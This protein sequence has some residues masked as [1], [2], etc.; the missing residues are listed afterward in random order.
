MGVEK[1]CAKNAEVKVCAHMAGGEITARIVVGSQFVPMVSAGQS[2][3]IVVEVP[4][5]VMVDSLKRAVFAVK[6]VLM[7]K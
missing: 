4:Y 5:V 3:K 2:A 1:A 7:A 6:N